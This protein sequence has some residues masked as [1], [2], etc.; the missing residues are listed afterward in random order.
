[1]LTSFLWRYA[2]LL[3]HWPGDVDDEFKDYQLT[4]SSLLLLGMLSLSVYLLTKTAN[5]FLT[6][7][8]TATS[9]LSKQQKLCML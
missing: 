1:M 3:C 4:V 8:L 7:K 5:Q 2:S 9:V 6:G